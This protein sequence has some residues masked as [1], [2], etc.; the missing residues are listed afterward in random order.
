MK[1]IKN[2]PMGN[3]MN[4]GENLLRLIVLMTHECVRTCRIENDCKN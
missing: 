4:V 1:R 3:Q 2:G